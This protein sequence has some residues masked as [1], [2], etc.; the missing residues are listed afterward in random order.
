[1]GL[2]QLIGSGLIA[3]IGC[4]SVLDLL[5]SVAQSVI[6][7]AKVSISA[8]CG[9]ELV[10]EVIAEVLAFRVI[11]SV[12]NGFDVPAIVWRGRGVVIDEV[13][14]ISCCD[15][16]PKI[17]LLKSFHINACKFF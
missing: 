4:D 12:N 13:K 16:F 6:C 7:P 10:F 17:A 9:D 15:V 1:M 5:N 11:K 3:I 8:T 2:I 14:D